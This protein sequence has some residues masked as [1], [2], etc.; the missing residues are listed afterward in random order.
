MLTGQTQKRFGENE[1]PLE[2]RSIQDIKT[3]LNASG[4]G[5]RIKNHKIL[6]GIMFFEVQEERDIKR[7]GRK[8]YVRHYLVAGEDPND[9]GCVAAIS[10]SDEERQVQTTH[11]SA[12]NDT[13]GGISNVAWCSSLQLRRKILRN[14]KSSRSYTAIKTVRRDYCEALLLEFDD[15]VPFKNQNW[16]AI[17]NIINRHQHLLYDEDD[18]PRPE[19]V[20]DEPDDDDDHD[21]DDYR[22]DD[23]GRDNVIDRDS[24]VEDDTINTNLNR[25]DQYDDHSL[26]PTHTFIP[27]SRDNSPEIVTTNSLDDDDID[28]GLT[29]TR[30][31]SDLDED[32]VI[33]SDYPKQPK[34]EPK[35]EPDP[36]IT[37]INKTAMIRSTNSFIDLTGEPDTEVIDLTGVDDPI[38]NRTS[39]GVEL[40]E[41]EDR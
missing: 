1:D 31:D 22:D 21:H 24:D 4:H 40:I 15:L 26:S 29:P 37:T 27:H 36:E 17:Q 10:L 13:R 33:I 39:S 6:S 5:A 25:F 2:P 28:M 20:G 9:E 7:L 23:Y 18:Q 8:S 34:L 11:M 16:Q 41:L 38:V 3:M 12:L 35:V 30:N 14:G 19:A 32:L